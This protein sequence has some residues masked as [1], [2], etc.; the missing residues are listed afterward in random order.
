MKIVSRSCPAS[1]P[2]SCFSKSERDWASRPTQSARI[3]WTRCRRYSFK[4]LTLQMHFPQDTDPQIIDG[5]SSDRK[6]T[7]RLRSRHLLHHR[8]ILLQGFAG[9]PV[10]PP[11]PDPGPLLSRLGHSR[12][13]CGVGSHVDYDPV[14]WLSRGG[15][16]GDLG[17]AV[18]EFCKY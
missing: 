3:I 4:S 8:I 16:V 15:S 1:K 17:H 18:C 10:P 9:L 5:G 11:N 13:M 2:Q 12:H 14:H 6:Q 7:G